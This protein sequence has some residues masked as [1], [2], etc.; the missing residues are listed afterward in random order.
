MHDKIKWYDPLKCGTYTNIEMYICTKMRYDEATD[1]CKLLPS[2]IWCHVVWQ[3]PT[4]WRNL[5]PPSSGQT[6]LSFRWRQQVP[7]KCRQ[8]FTRPH[9]ITTART[10]NLTQTNKRVAWPWNF[11]TTPRHQIKLFL[12]THFYGIILRSV[13]SLPIGTTRKYLICEATVPTEQ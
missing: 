3:L 7:P 4:F 5:M 11:E 2:W 13:L 9:G 1:K 6:L 12:Q 8:L 10:S